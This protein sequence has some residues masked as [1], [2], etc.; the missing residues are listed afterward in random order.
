M[1]VGGLNWWYNLFLETMGNAIPADQQD[2][3]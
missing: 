3:I 1:Y 2:N